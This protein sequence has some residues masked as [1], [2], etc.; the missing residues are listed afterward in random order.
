M[1]NITL[2]T[3]SL[4]EALTEVCQNGGRVYLYAD[5][6]CCTWERCDEAPLCCLFV[7]ETLREDNTALAATCEEAEEMAWDIDINMSLTQQAK[8]ALAEV[9]EED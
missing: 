4:H 1:K 7:S 3:E 2:D 6:Y 8:E 5:G 9:V